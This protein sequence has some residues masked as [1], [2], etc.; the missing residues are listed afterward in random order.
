MQRGAGLIQEKVIRALHAEGGGI[1]GRASRQL[2]RTA[3]ASARSIQEIAWQAACAFGR[4]V[5][6][7]APADLGAAGL[8]QVGGW[9]G[10]VSFYALAAVCG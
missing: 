4:V 8:A 2:G 7:L 10:D 3:L 1:T 5:A 6:S 9:V